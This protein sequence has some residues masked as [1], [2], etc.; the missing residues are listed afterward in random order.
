MKVSEPF[1]SNPPVS[2]YTLIRLSRLA[3]EESLEQAHSSRA[4]TRMRDGSI[5]EES[6]EEIL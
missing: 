4:I 1:G 2:D 6:F 3:A 5:V